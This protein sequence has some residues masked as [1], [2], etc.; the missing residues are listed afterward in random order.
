LEVFYVGIL[1]AGVSPHPPMLIPEVGGREIAGV[2]RTQEALEKLSAAIAAAQPETVII[3]TP[4]GPLHKDAPVALAA[5]NLAG[6]FGAFGAPGVRLKAENDLELVQALAEASRREKIDLIRL[7]AETLD[8][9][10]TVPLYHLQ[11]A[12]TGS[13]CVALTYAL[14][15]YADL[16]RFGQ[17]LQRAADAVGRRVAVVASADLSHRLL[18]G[19]PAG[20]DPRGREFDEKVVEYLQNYQVEKLLTI[21]PALVDAA[22]ECGLRSLSILL[23]SLDGLPVQPEVLSY[24]GPFGVGYPVALFKLPPAE[25]AGAGCRKEAGAADG[26]IYLQIARQSLES[27]LEGRAFALPQDL[28][29]E[30]QQP[31]AAFVTLKKEGALRGCIGTIYPVQNTLAA[32]IAANAVS[33]GLNDPRFSPV[34]QAELE[35]LSYSVDVLTVPEEVD[36]PAELDPRRYGII[37]RS[38]GR[39]GL[40][41]PALEGVAAVEKQLAIAKQK[42]GIRP[43]EAVEIFRF[44]VYRYTQENIR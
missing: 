14:L 23:G 12:G 34:T 27:R 9:G 7:Q 43:D 4:H 31:G 42:A 25:A 40:L 39:T 26:N 22:G 8:H 11:A 32:E 19:G 21:D 6:D 17:A 29:A 13:R 1:I 5:E 44:E 33:A 36:S 28:P 20:Y 2:R 30:L 24:E 41:L 35:M 16:F 10:V 15:P 38:G 18:R 3:I 37:V